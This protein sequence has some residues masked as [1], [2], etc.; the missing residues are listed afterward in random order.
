MLLTDEA[1]RKKFPEIDDEQ[2]DFLLELCQATHEAGTEQSSGTLADTMRLI[3]LTKQNLDKIE[4]A[5]AQ[6]NIPPWTRFQSAF[7]RAFRRGKL[8][9]LR[10]QQTN[11]DT[12]EMKEIPSA[13][14]H[15]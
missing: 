7:L 11:K 9:A 3:A 1:I 12:Q 5:A 10:L 8:P 14:R 13:H 2:L 4:Q 15:A 6:R